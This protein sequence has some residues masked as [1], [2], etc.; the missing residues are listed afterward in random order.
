M[1][2]SDV[3][4]TLGNLRVTSTPTRKDNE[5]PTGTGPI[6]SGVQDEI[7]E[8]QNYQNRR[9]W[10]VEKPEPVEPCTFVSTLDDVQ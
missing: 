9:Y 4:P 2:K 6:V 1:N 7:A 10:V 3:L 5:F 8:M